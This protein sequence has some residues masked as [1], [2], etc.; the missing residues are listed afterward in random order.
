MSDTRIREEELKRLQSRYPAEEGWQIVEVEADNYD[1]DNI[2]KMLVKDHPDVIKKNHV[3]TLSHGEYK[4][5]PSLIGKTA[6][7]LGKVKFEEK[8]W[9][10]LLEV[11][12]RSTPIILRRFMIDVSHDRPERVTFIITK[13][14][15]AAEDLRAKVLMSYFNKKRKERMITVLSGP[16]IPI[17]DIGWNDLFLPTGMAEAIRKSVESFFNARERFKELNLPYK[18]GFLFVGP[19]G[20][21]KTQ[22]IRVI[23]AT[24]R[25][26][27]ITVQLDGFLDERNIWNA[28]ALAKD[29]APAIIVLEELDKII[30][31]YAVKLPYIVSI[32]DGLSPSEGILILATS[33]NPEKLDP[34]LL[35]RPGRFDIVWEF[36]QPNFTQRLGILKR[37]GGN[38]FSE[39]VLE[40]CARETQGLSMAY[41]QEVVVNALLLA[42]HKEENPTDND[43]L[44][45]LKTIKEQHNSVEK[46]C[47][48]ASGKNAPGFT[49]G[50]GKDP[51]ESSA[52]EEEQKC[53]SS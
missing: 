5:D 44:A 7:E 22:T 11:E 16:D 13:N 24:S 32:I 50:N 14:P 36:P 48:T 51:V 35:K 15:S 25:K 33:N 23:A 29:T 46:G 6:E 41:V 21:G 9:S 30:S 53:H 31:K 27:V 8:D 47:Q 45:S 40:K 26:P 2:Y 38:H 39:N 52:A 34:A 10:G 3:V 12:W 20:N 4:R 49:N 43:L 37:R 17:A 1:T 18:R 28:F 42:I 19:P